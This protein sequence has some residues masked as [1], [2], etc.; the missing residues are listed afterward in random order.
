MK[1][2]KYFSQTILFQTHLFGKEYFWMEDVD[3]TTY[4][5]KAEPVY[6]TVNGE[7]VVEGYRPVLL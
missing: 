6:T 5:A 2:Q 3:G 4:L 1:K 7:E